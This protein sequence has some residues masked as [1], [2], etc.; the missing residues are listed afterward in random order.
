MV[1]LYEMPF[2]DLTNIE[3]ISLF[4]LNKKQQWDDVILDSKLSE[5]VRKLYGDN[6]FRSLSCN[7]ITHDHFNHTFYN[8]ITSSKKIVLYVLHLN[9]KS[10]NAKHRLLCQLLAVLS[11]Q[12]D[13][14]VLS[15]LWSCNIEFYKNILVNYNFYYK[16][17]TSSRAEGI[18]MY[19][20]SDLGQHV[21][22]AYDLINMC[23]YKVEDLWLEITNKKY[24]ILNQCWEPHLV[25]FRVRDTLVLL[26]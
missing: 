1:D 3:L 6:V 7:Y 18:G 20:N 2:V 24:Q 10:L 16:Q 14:I 19:V 8:N 4:N 25:K 12:F 11:L 26:L 9:I 22:T 5:H 17:P 13:V 23:S 21:T 15:E